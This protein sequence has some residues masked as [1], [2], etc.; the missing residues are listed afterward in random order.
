VKSNPS[1]NPVGEKNNSAGESHEH[2]S[3]NEEQKSQDKI[4]QNRN[5]TPRS[6]TSTKGNTICKNQFFP[7][8]INTIATD[9]RRSPPSLPH[10]IEN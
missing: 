8:R 2:E 4:T 7:L 10:L 5:T 1:R 3:R 9:P 6:T